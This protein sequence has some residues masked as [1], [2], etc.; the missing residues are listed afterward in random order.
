MKQLLST[1]CAVAVAG[2]ATAALAD[3]GRTPITVAPPVVYPVEPETN[4]T[5]F[6]GGIFGGFGPTNVPL[7]GPLGISIDTRAL[8]LRAGYMHDFGQWVAIGEVSAENTTIPGFPLP[9]GF[10]IRRYSIDAM[11]GYDAGN[12]MP[13]VG[14][15]AAQGRLTTPGPSITGS[16]PSLSVGLAYRPTEHVMLDARVRYTRYS[17]FGVRLDNTTFTLGISWHQ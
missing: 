1:I 15:G 6:Y 9:A 8:G 5:G 13:F 17:P 16:G 12:I 3:G 11:L 4:W 7:V 2:T 10:N 14:I